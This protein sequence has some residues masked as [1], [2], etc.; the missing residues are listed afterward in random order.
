M[1]CLIPFLFLIDYISRM[2]NLIQNS[3]VGPG[4]DHDFYLKFIKFYAYTIWTVVLRWTSLIHQKKKKKV[5]ISNIKQC[6]NY[7]KPLCKVQ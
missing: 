4:Y 7:L 2:E 3:K 1:T 5:D 6:G